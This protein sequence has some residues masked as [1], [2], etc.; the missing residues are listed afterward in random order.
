MRLI[1]KARNKSVTVFIFYTINKSDRL[2]Y[3]LFA[4]SIDEKFMTLRSLCIHAHFYQPPRE[5]PLT[6]IIPQEA[7]A[8]PYSNWNERILAECYRPNADLGNFE[9]ISFNIGPTLLQWI[10]SQD[11][12]TW[13]NIVHQDRLNIQRYG[14]GNAI[15]Q[16]YNH[17]ILPLSSPRDQ[18]TQIIWGM[19]EFEQRF[20]RKPQGMWLP[21]TAVNT[22]TLSLL[23][24]QGIEFTILAPWQ[25]DRDD[26]D[27]SQPYRVRLAEGQS[28]IAFFYHRE[29]SGGISF[30][31]ANTTNADLFA[32]SE[33]LPKY[34]NENIRAGQP[35]LLMIATDGELYGHHQ[36]FRDQFLA[37]LVNGAV[38][39]F[40]I[41]PT[42]PGLWLRS[43]SVKRSVGIRENTSW[44]CHHG[45]G[46][47]LGNCPC[48][49]GDG[50]W[51]AQLR[52]AFERVSQEIDKIYLQTLS[53]IIPDPWRLR[54]RYIYAMLGLVAAEELICEEADRRLAEDKIVQIQMLLEAQRERQRMYTSCG[55]FFDDFDRIEPK[56]NLAYA[57]QAVR[58]VRLASGVDLEPYIIHDL[59]KI[60]SPGTRLRADRIFQYYLHRAVLDGRL[61]AGD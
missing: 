48:T 24:R 58:L 50:G 38:H 51:K 9:N 16:S 31:P 49:P 54:N 1:L 56:N 8:A 61:I 59:S 11:S 30:N 28:I 22:D 14:V 41:A 19:A 42:Y 37:H 5:D 45:L 21:E 52:Y 18:E 32:L 33:L 2:S 25:A 13:Q 3:T 26:I 57:S 20:G 29:L 43:H 12:N 53:P 39:K 47:W 6:G 27:V 17:T 60:S 35:Q 55:W 40:D 44:S 46:R 10:A 36:P 23:A 34:Q 4:A 7:G 15:A